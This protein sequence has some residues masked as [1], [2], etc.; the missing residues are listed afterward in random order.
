MKQ[1]AK[2]LAVVCLV[3]APATA[4]QQPPDGPGAQQPDAGRSLMEK[5]ARM[6]LR[7]LMDEA[8]PALEGLR[9]FA[10]EMTPA[11]R[12]FL[13]EMGPALAGL[14]ERVEDI[15]NYHPPEMLPNGDIIL[16]RKREAP[17]LRPAPPEGEIEL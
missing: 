13:R 14:L 17:A 1:V 3:A 7:G 9:D 4:E 8:D 16:R 6:F 15:T 11:V 5:G 10:G 12:D 2:I